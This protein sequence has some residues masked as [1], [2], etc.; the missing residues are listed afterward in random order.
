MTKYTP[1]LTL[2]YPEAGDAPR[3]NEQIQALAEALDK[4]PT[5]W[6]VCTNAVSFTT[7]TT[8]GME[9]YPITRVAGSPS[10]AADAVNGG[11]VVPVGGYY[12]ADLTVRWNTPTANSRLSV[13]MNGS[14]PFGAMDAAATGTTY[15]QSVSFLCVAA[16]GSSVFPRV[17]GFTA[18]QVVSYGTLAVRFLG[19][20]DAAALAA[21]EQAAG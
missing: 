13:G 7:N 4:G 6:A 17:D 1:N 16:A 2:P 21:A 12:L 15:V 10:M 18:A 3:G 11:V 9:T 8:T 20:A 14:T 19:P 5:L